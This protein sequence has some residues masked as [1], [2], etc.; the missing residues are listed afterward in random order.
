M[1]SGTALR[2]QHEHV[3]ISWLYPRDP[4][5]SPAL[6]ARTDAAVAVS[7]SGAAFAERPP[8]ARAGGEPRHAPATYSP[9]N[10]QH[11][12]GKRGETGWLAIAG[13]GER[14]A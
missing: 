7:V 3:E 8:P 5:S 10:P 11:E 9:G 1:S 12:V 13:L 4:V 2:P 14:R 6:S